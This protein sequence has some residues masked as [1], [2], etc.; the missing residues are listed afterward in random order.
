M[1]LLDKLEKRIGRFALTNVT[2]Y[3]IAGQVIFYVLW[4][5]N[6]FDLQ[7]ILL[8]ADRV[9]KG[10]I[11]RLF[12]FAFV[13]PEWNVVF[14]FFAWY[15]FYLMGMALENHWGAFRYNIFLLI[16]YLATVGVSFLT[17]D[18]P[19]TNAF[20]GGSVFLA[21][22][23]LYPDFAV[24]LFFILPVKVKWLALV[25][26]IFYFFS[27]VFGGWT[28]RLTI[29][30][31]VANFL[32]FFGRDIVAKIKAGRRRM[33][34]QAQRL[35]QQNKPFHQCAVCGKTDRSHPN[36]EFRYCGQ[37]KPTRCY[38]K[39]HIFNHEHIVKTQ[40]NRKS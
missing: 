38:C 11:W 30:A 17:P 8:I 13:P 24:Y 2:L 21:F 10:E 7:I 36:M 29:L 35:A 40:D 25:T 9:L 34:V 20:I 32:L 4:L 1:N 37:C 14:A 5:T 16:G 39:D 15:L 23:F 19:L 18:M 31:S 26:W 22:A 27:F 28:T 6:R 3:I 12:T 33:A